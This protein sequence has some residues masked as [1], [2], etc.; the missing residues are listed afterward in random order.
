MDKAI[1]KIKLDCKKIKNA[2]ISNEKNVRV[3]LSEILSVNEKERKFVEEILGLF[4][5]KPD[6]IASSEEISSLRKR[7]KISKAGAWRMTKKLE[8][9]GIIEVI[10]RINTKRFYMLSPKFDRALY[11]LARGYRK[12]RKKEI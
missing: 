10:P 12:F 8:N 3:L 9:F 6:N 1:K 5:N 11:K 2:K 4:R 7:Q